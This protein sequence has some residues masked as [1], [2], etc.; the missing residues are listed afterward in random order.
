MSDLKSEPD[1]KFLEKSNPAP[2]KNHFRSTTLNFTLC[3]FVVAVITEPSPGRNNYSC[4]LL[5]RA[6]SIQSDVNGL[7]DIARATFV[8]YVDL[9]EEY[10]QVGWYLPSWRKQCFRCSSRIEIIRCPYFIVFRWQS[11]GF[12]TVQDPHS[13]V[14]SDPGGTYLI[15]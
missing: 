2:K 13:N 7:L 1:P 15:K 9:L 10:V 5:N 3:L 4:N 14:D 6:L 12:R 8:E 11:A